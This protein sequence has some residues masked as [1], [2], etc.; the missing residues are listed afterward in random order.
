MLIELTDA[1]AIFVSS[2]IWAIFGVASGFVV[3]RLP[4]RLLNEDTWLTR[5][6]SWE[7]NGRWYD[8]RLRIRIWKD[9]LPEWG[10]LFPGGTSK[11]SLPGRSQ[12]DLERF[13]VETRRAEYVHWANL[14]VGPT[15]LIWCSPLLGA[16]MILFGV[17]AH[18]PFICIQRYNRERV[19]RTLTRRAAR[20]V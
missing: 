20:G 14:G 17:M 8:R 9:R 12:Q 13:L 15:F 7:D 4:Q 10:D 3:S 5:A 18:I 19:V 11:R 6:R 16:C 1:A 2:V